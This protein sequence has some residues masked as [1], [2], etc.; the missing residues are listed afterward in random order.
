MSMYTSDGKPFEPLTRG[1]AFETYLASLGYGAFPVLMRRHTHGRTLVWFGD[2]LGAYAGGDGRTGDGFLTQIN[3]YLGMEMQ[4]RGYAGSNWTSTGAGDC[5]TRI[6]QLLDDGVAYDVVLLAWGTNGDTNLGAV[7]DAPAKDG[8]MCAVMKWA[9]QSIRAAYPN[10]G[11]GIIIPPPGSGGM[12]CSEEKANLMIEC[13]RSADMHVPYLDMWHEGYIVGSSSISDGSNGL[14]Y[15]DVHL[16][17]YGRNRYAS[18]LAPF[19]ER[20]CPY[21]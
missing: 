11:V 14:G 13:C 15:Q 3:K 12:G 19:I 10:T 18:A 21:I 8:S 1:S 2:S 17:K 4:N 20:L 16:S 6:Q 7:T 9:V 5:P